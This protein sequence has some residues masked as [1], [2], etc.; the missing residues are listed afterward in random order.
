MTTKDL[1]KLRDIP[2]WDIIGVQM[3]GKYISIPCPFHNDTNPSLC[4]YDNNSYYCFGCKEKGQGA[5]D[6]LVSSGMSIQESIKELD[7]FIN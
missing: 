1:K 3:R 6:F 5:I 4:I 7:N 2:I